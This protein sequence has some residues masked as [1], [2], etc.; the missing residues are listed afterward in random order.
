MRDLGN[1]NCLNISELKY[2]RKTIAKVKQKKETAPKGFPDH[3]SK[4]GTFHMGSK[5]ALKDS[6]P[7]SDRLKL[8]FQGDDST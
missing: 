1:Y 4:Q 5:K 3:S 8:M 2:Q 6:E 7:F